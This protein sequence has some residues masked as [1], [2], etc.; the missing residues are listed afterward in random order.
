[1]TNDR[2][3]ERE[4]KTPL[5]S[6]P[7]NFPIKEKDKIDLICYYDHL[8]KPL[9][10]LF[11][12]PTYEKYLSSHFNLL[13]NFYKNNKKDG[14]YESDHW[15]EFLIKRFDIIKNYISNNQDKWAVFSDVDV[16]FFDNF[17]NNL[18]YYKDKIKKV[19]VFYMAETFVSPKYEVN[20]GFFLFKCSN[21]AYDYFDKVQKL[22][23]K[24]EKPNDQT[25][26]QNLLKNKDNDK[27][28]FL[29]KR[30][31]F[32][33]NNPRKITLNLLNC[34]KVFHAT[35]AKNPVEKS[36]VLSSVFFY[37]FKE[38]ENKSNLWM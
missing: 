24:M 11:F 2:Y 20:G 33:N 17:Y 29:D 15:C 22:T 21:Y 1:M 38:E 35:S 4:M 34:I 7:K 27:I 5:E 3:L 23:E 19:E 14:S 16:L 12:Y 25:L 32:T 18:N 31:F 6:Y 10:D 30:I 8:H 36:Q 28:D 13:D 37:K 9:F 26:M